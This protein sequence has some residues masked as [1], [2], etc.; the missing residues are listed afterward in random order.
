[1][2]DSGIKKVTIPKASLPDVTRDNQ[3]LVR[4]RIVSEDRNRVSGW[5]PVFILD[6]K[7]V[8]R[9]EPS[10][11][12]HSIT[13]SIISLAWTDQEARPSYDIFVK[14]DNNEYRYH[15]TTTSTNYT[16]RNEGV[17]SFRFAIQ[18]PSISKTKSE[19]LEIYESSPIPLV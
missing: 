13:N 18:V 12:A 2:V 17:S 16:L 5:S 14:F 8:T 10:A 7:P 6:A 1:M 15:G 4:Y 11:V 19:E 9:L 3:Y